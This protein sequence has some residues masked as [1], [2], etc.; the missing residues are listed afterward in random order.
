MA[1]A[2]AE[3]SIAQRCCT[4]MRREGSRCLPS[5]CLIELAGGRANHVRD[6]V[7]RPFTMS[8]AESVPEGFRPVKRVSMPAGELVKV[9]TLMGYEITC[10]ENHMLACVGGTSLRARDL[11]PDLN[12]VLLSSRALYDDTS[13]YTPMEFEAGKSIGRTLGSGYILPEESNEYIDTAGLWKAVGICKGLREHSVDS[14]SDLLV[15]P[16]FTL[17]ST[18]R[19]IHRLLARLGVSSALRTDEHDGIFDTEAR[20]T[21]APMPMHARLFDIVTCPRLAAQDSV[22]EALMCL[23]PRV[24]PYLSTFRDTVESI[25]F[26]H[27][28][29]GADSST[30]DVQVYDISCPGQTSPHTIIA[31]GFLTHS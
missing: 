30:G 10:T 6:L 16:T 14:G 22:M 9:R 28:A 8:N 1:A 3:P 21:I 13:P 12:D 23:G 27:D 15:F 29:E 20:S 2:A 24:Q 7:G 19:S 25:S 17:K 26:V 11:A 4:H 5:T 31:D 18:V